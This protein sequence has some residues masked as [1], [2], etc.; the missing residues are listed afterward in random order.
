MKNKQKILDSV[1]SAN[2]LEALDHD[3]FLS[4]WKALVFL[5][6]GLHPDD[7][8]V[9]GSGWPE[10]LAP[11]VEEAFRRYDTGLIG[12]GEFYCYEEAKKGILATLEPNMGKG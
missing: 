8:D 3:T 7:F 9:E 11:I 1:M 5:N 4:G 10:E 2:S 6:P 12:E